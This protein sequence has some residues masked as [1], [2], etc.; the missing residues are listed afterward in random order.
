MNVWEAGMWECKDTA[1]SW[2]ENLQCGPIICF[3]VPTSA[4][5]LFFLYVTSFS[6]RSALRSAEFA[7]ILISLT[8][9]ESNSEALEESSEGNLTCSRN[10]NQIFMFMQ[11]QLPGHSF[12]CHIQKWLLL[13]ATV[14]SQAQNQLIR[15]STSDSFPQWWGFSQNW[16]VVVVSQKCDF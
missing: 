8:W 6:P 4:A 11:L 16:I 13:S 10:C 1:S 7:L 14:T 12:L 3:N 15:W 5:A 2:D 9:N